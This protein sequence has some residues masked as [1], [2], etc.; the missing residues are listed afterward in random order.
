MTRRL[1]LALFLIA[2][3]TAAGLLAH[4]HPSPTKTFSGE[5]ALGDVVSQVAFGDRSPG[6]PGHAAT[7][8]SIQNSLTSAG[9][10][11]QVV[12]QPYKG[13]TVKNLVATRNF[14]LDNRPLL[15][16][17]AHYDTRARAD[18]ETEQANQQL[19]VPGANDGASG[20]AVLLELARTLPDHLPV[21]VQLVFFDAEDQGRLNGWD[22][23]V[24]STQLAELANPLPDQLIV[25]D[26]IGDADQNI[27]IERSS[28]QTLST[29][30]WTIAA[31]LRY[32][33]HF[34]AQPKY[35]IID[36]HAPFLAQG[37]TAVDI[38]DFDYP[39]WHTLADT[40]DKVSA[41]SLQRIGDVL[42]E[43][44]I[45]FEKYQP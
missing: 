32:A 2:A 45:G 4:R 16:L 35:T 8:A 43:Y 15:W 34:I 1:L 23:I 10:Q 18:Q 39:Y 26:M 41:Q 25:I 17:G 19:P 37:V 27:Y 14:S 29:T 11:S 40:P 24:G 20:V 3:L 7:V 13:V 38:I 21:N 44:V 33:E 22:W 12:G 6:T 30:L 9:W 36:D 31:D 5:A 28:N 42:T